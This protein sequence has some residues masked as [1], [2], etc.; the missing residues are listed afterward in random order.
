MASSARTRQISNAA[1]FLGPATVMLMGMLLF[2]IVVDF[3][4]AFSN[5]SQTIRTDGL[6]LEQFGKIIRPSEEAL[7]GFELRGSFYRAMAL[8]A[9]FVVLTLAFFN[10]TFALILALTTTALPDR[11]G[12]FFRAIWLLPRM[13]P[14]VVYGLLWLWVIDPTPRGLLN[15][16]AVNLFG[17]EPINMILDHPMMVIVVANGFIGASLGMI[18]LTSAIRSI[19]DHLFYAARADGAGP[20]S[21]VRHIVLPALRW[22]LSYIT[23]FQTLA[24]LVS[25]EYIFLIMGAS[26]STMTLAMLAYTKSLAPGI[27]AGQYAYGAAIT[28]IL[29][30]L[31]IGVSLLLW[32]VTNM[33]GLLQPAKIEVQ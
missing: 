2:P 28:M 27:G 11:V 30:V 16:V 22:P 1:I 24:L 10:I 25:F 12:S 20:M 14:S 33:R 8:T 17:M 4:V 6:S 19:P 15:Q 29:I 18:I 5:M 3:F 21:I 26:R 32:R 13:S 23:I 31:G 9:V 7:L